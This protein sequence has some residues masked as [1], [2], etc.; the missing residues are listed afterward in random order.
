MRSIQA[1]KFL[2][3]SV[4]TFGLKLMYVFAL[5]LNKIITSRSLYQTKYDLS[6]HQ[7]DYNKEIRS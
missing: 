3:Q 4:M 5:Y 7:F 2:E 1:Q 6:I